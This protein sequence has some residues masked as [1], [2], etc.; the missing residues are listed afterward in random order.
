MFDASGLKPRLRAGGIHLGLSVGVAALAALLVFRVWYPPPFATLAGGFDLFLLLVS[1][2]VVIGPVLTTVAASA[3]KPRPELV[4]DL[5]VIVTLQLAAFGYGLYSMAMARPVVLT[6]E[7]DLFR[8]VSAADV[9]TDTL[10]EAPPALR[11]L[12]W[13][14]P[15][16]IAAVKP[17]DASEQ[18]KSIELG[19]A[20]VHL[21]YI[22]RFW[23][24][25][26]SFSDAAWR[27][28][29][30][31]AEVIARYPEAR[32]PAALIAQQSGRP[33]QELRFVPLVARRASWIAVVA[34]PGATI[35]GYLPV[36]G[37]F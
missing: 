15:R 2:D 21:S 22:P 11:D 18:L 14:G 23:R 13:A 28:A 8:V 32:E 37:F 17:L 30:P 36:D 10:A 3:G 34:S 35:V 19:L 9:D 31:L 20:G 33:L 7:V 25:Y 6:F 27:A 16:L 26:A 4:R 5:A 12:S 24:D 29:R 1:V